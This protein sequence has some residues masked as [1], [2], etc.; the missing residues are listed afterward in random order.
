VTV[1]VEAIYGHVPGLHTSPGKP[2]VEYVDIYVVMAES[3][4]QAL[5]DAN[6]RAGTKP[7]LSLRAT[8]MSP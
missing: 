3:T 7:L 1:L 2:V 4:R 6:I 5:L 8:E